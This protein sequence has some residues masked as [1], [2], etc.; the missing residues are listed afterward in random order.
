MAP[1]VEQ[2]V[3][4]PFRE[5]SG[6][7]RRLMRRYGH[8]LDLFYDI[9]V[10]NGWQAIVT[11]M[12]DEIAWILRREPGTADFRITRL[13]EADGMLAVDVLNLPPVIAGEVRRVIEKAQ[14]RSRKTCEV[15]GELR[16][17][18]AADGVGT[19]CLTF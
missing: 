13:Y 9:E 3:M 8:W 4:P 12:M 14:E 6:W 7:R 10:Q 11:E 17:N 15:C 19:A 16:G 1:T 5:N 18:H 2:V